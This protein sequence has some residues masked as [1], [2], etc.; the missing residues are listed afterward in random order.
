MLAHCNVQ[1]SDPSKR[2]TAW[3]LPPNLGHE[4]K[5]KSV[6]LKLVGGTEPRKFY[7]GIRRTLSFE[8]QNISVNKLEPKVNYASVA[9]KILLFK[10]KK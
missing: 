6:V 1:T 8:I 2:F 10:E 7:V 4:L 5:V 3:R 9:H